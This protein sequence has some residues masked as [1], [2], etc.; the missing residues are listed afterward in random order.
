MAVQT[1]GIK[2]PRDRG[3]RQYTQ[4]T[5][6]S[7]DA[8]TAKTLVAAKAGHISVI[9]KL[10]FICDAAE[11]VSILVDTDELVGDMPVAANSMISLEGIHCPTANKAITIKTANTSSV[12]A[13]IHYHYE[14]D[15]T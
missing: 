11:T 5:I 14:G 13:F 15:A 10:W 7:Q 12:T 4:S 2:P 3:G 9:D 1:F 6:E 8:S